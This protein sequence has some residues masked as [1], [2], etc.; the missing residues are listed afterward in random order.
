MTRRVLLVIALA[1]CTRGSPECPG[2][3]LMGKRPPA[4]QLEWCARSDGTKHGRW[5]EWYPSGTPK[6]VGSYVDGK[7]EGTWR[8]YHEDGSLKSEGAYKGGFKDGTW[9]IYY[10]K[11]DGGKKNRVE[12]HQAGAPKVDW[13]VFRPD[14]SKWAEGSSLAARQDGPYTEY[15][16]N[17]Q[18]AAKGTYSA[19]EKSG[20]W[21]YFDAEGKPS[22]TPTGNSQQP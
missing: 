4:G 6:S 5:S 11:G 7:M 16:A 19:G 21:L 10:S 18:V 1:G 13:V 2:T 17:G 14:G 8:S 9:T 20:Q 3:Q 22:A 15:H 12:Q